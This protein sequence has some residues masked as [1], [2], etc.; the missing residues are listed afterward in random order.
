MIIRSIEKNELN[1]L[2]ELYTHLHSGDMPLLPSTELAK[3]WND[4]IKNPLLHYFV[5]EY[6]SKLVSSCTLSIIPNLT[7]G[8]RSYGVIENVVTHAD[9]RRRGLGKAVLKNA[10]DFAWKSNCY[11]V[12]LLS[13]MYRNEAHGLYEKAGF[14]KDA[15]V[16]Y[17]AKPE[18]PELK[19]GLS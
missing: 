3:L 1:D 6:E 9:Y 18:H 14:S 13:G 2:L 11:K 12:M 19:G 8:A 10:L 16:G 7:R 5:A 17:V 15:K 4:I